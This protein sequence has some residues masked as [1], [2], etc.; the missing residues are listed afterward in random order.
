MALRGLILL[1][2]FVA[3]LPV[4]FI[5][6]FYGI[7]LWT[8]VAFL[9]PQSFL[10]GNAGV[11][12]WAMA[13]AIPTLAGFV[14]F[15]RDTRTLSSAKTILI[16]C[17]WI[18]FTITSVVSNYAPLFAHHSLDTWEKWRLV[19]K[20]LLMAVVTAAITN[21]FERLRILMLTIAGCFGVF[22]AKTFP[23]ILATGGNFRLYGPENSM[24][25]DNNDFG[26]ALNMTLPLFFFLALSERKV[27]VKRMFGCLFLM[28]IPAVFF[29]YSRGALVGLVVVGALM[30]LQVRQRFFLIPVVALAAMMAVLFAPDNWKKRMDLTSSDVVDASAEERLNAWQFSWNL[31]MEYP[32]TGGGFA[33]FTPDL[34]ARYAPVA[35]DIHGAH[36]VYFGLLAEH[37]FVGLILYL[38][39]V[40]SCFLTTFRIIREARA[41]GDITVVHY[42]NMLRFSLVGFLSSGFFLGRAY[43]D[44][45]FTIVVC[46]IVLEKVIWQRWETMEAEE[47]EPDENPE[48]AD[49]YP[50]EALPKSGMR[51]ENA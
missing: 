51:F 4:C 40:A 23:F 33:T 49:V 7:L 15:N 50:G 20:V 12:P 6:P 48:D 18:W 11:F 29:T 38:I 10:W 43:F 5:R 21:S 32:I 41:R 1:V 35:N 30:F 31:A 24:I 9:N 16:V 44:Y 36:S 47:E 19:S 27:W 26:L 14:V 37:G 46:I 45:F 28:T 39:L 2:V 3:S 34:F 17:L 25:G 13:V 22:V 8:I 42:A